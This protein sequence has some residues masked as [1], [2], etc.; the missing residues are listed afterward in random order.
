MSNRI[1]WRKWGQ[2][3]TGAAFATIPHT[4]VNAA[5]STN[6]DDVAVAS[7]AG[8]A[9][10]N[11]PTVAGGPDAGATIR[12]ATSTTTPDARDETVVPPR[13]SH[14]LLPSGGRLLLTGGVSTIEGAAGGGL[15]TWALIGGYGTRDEIGVS[16]FGTGVFTR[17][18]S[19]LSYGASVGFYNRVELSVAHQNFNLRRVG[20]SLGLGPDY[21]IN[22]TI[23]GAKVRLVGDA[24]IDQDKWLPQI[25]VGAQYKSN[26][27]ALVVGT[28][29]G[30][31]RKSV[32][33]YIAATKLIL[34]DNLLVNTTL[35]LTKA[36]QYGILGFGGLGG[37]DQAYKPQ[38]EGSVAYLLTRKLA[39]GG[40]VRTK[41]NRLEGALGGST[42]K[43]QT[44]FDAFVAYA[45]IRNFSLT[46]AYADLGQIA[47]RNQHGVYLSAQVGF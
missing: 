42:F 18:F 31:R 4:A 14:G 13:S 19:L 44:A 39:I 5:V 34:A 2:L 27:N 23:I 1:T 46:L 29:L 41:S 24:V 3:F 8:D 9:K 47:L 36:N 32:D 40:E 43:E 35:R 6:M 7:S 15:S 37:K 28:V 16:T 22:Q 45:P 30:V 11:A 20:A 17:D 26:E 38:F 21:F 10:S 12:D 33:F 25:S